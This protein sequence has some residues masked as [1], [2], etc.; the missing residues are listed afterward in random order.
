MAFISIRRRDG[1]WALLLGLGLACAPKA[2]RVS[3]KFDIYGGD[4]AFSATVYAQE[5][6]TGKTHSFVYH[7]HTP[8]IT[9]EL[10]E[11]GKYVFYARLVEA[12][13]DYHYGYTNTQP[14][15]YGH[16]TRGGTQ[17]PAKASLIAVPVQPGG[18]YRVY[19]NDY[20][21]ILPEPGKPVTVPWR[22]GP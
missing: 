11:P 15:A 20:R 3:V 17:D 12:P 22:E 16:G 1:A 5:V 6:A 21:A 14:V 8:Y 18:S 19:I 13:D 10:A 9:A 4:N 2:A 7:P